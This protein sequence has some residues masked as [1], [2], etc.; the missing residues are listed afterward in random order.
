MTAKAKRPGSAYPS[1]S[2]RQL[3]QDLEITDSVKNRMN[4]AKAY[5]QAGK[6]PESIELLEKSLD[7]VH[8]DDLN[9]IE[10]LCHSYFY[11]GNFDKLFEYLQKHEELNK[12]LP[13]SL[14]LLK[15]RAHEET[16][17][18]ETALKEYE[19][20]FNIYT[21][22]EA[23]CRYALLLKKQGYIEKA[24]EMFGNILKN[25]KLYPKQ[26]SNFE[27]EWVKISKTEIT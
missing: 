23:R 27:K 11:N 24:N 21:G 22:E 13:N 7:G 8:A 10:G 17:D 2:I 15:A 1:K 5:F 16:G 6:Y 14:R 3:K 25:A 18:L 19:A 12:E 9:I 26:Y 4:L 20:I